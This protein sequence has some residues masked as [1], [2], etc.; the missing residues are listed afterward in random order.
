MLW[1][2]GL[3]KYQFLQNILET[4]NSAQKEA[5]THKDGPLL[6]IA[7]AG[8]GKTRVLTHRILHLIESK[9][10]SAEQIL[11]LTFTEKA[12]LEVQERLDVLLPYG[13]SELWAKTFHG[14]ADAILRE[15]GLE[16]GL[17]TAYQILSQTDLVLLL[18]KHLFE[19][20]LKYYRPLGNPLR[21][22]SA[23]GTHFGH[24]R[25]ELVTP[26]A[27][28]EY[29]E[30]MEGEEE[31]IAKTIE[32]A[33]AYKK[34]DELLL[35]KG[36]LDFATLQY[37]AV[38][39]LE[40]KPSIL[41]EYKDRFRYVLVDEYQDTN[42]AQN[43]LVELI[44]ESHK[45]LMVVGDDDQCIYKWRGASLSNILQ[46]EQNFKD[47]KKVVLTENYRSTQPVLDLS[48]AVIQNN[49]PFRLE[50]RAGIDKKLNSNLEGPAP[51][52]HS[53]H[54]S[55]YSKE[56][57]FVTQHIQ[58]Y[59]NETKGVSYRDVAILVRAT[60]H[61]LPFLE[62]LKQAGIP[63]YFSG[64]Q[65]LYLRPEVKDLLSVLR[66][67]ANPYDDVALFRF[68][69]MSIFS[70]ET[71]YLVGLVHKSKTTTTPLLK[72][73]REVEKE[74][75]LFAKTDPNKISLESFL[76]L[77]EELQTMIKDSAT[78]QI[79]GVFLKKSGYLEALEQDETPESME[80]L[81]N[82]AAFSQ[83]IRSFEETQGSPRLNE[84]LDYLLS[85]QEMGDRTSPP[86]EALDSDT[87]KILTVH[88]AKGLEFDTVLLVDLVQ[89]RFPSI[90][91][92][93]PLTVPEDLLSEQVDQEASHL[94]EERRLFYVAATRAKRHLFLTHS[95][96]YDGK[97]R[98]KPSVFLKEAHNFMDSTEDG[99]KLVDL[100]PPTK[101]VAATDSLGDQP[102]LFTYERRHQP[103]KLSFSRINTFQTCPLRYK[104]QYLYRLAEPLSHQLSFGS[105]VH[106][107]L[108]AFY[109][110]VKQ[111]ATPSLKRLNELYEKH[112]IPL[113]Y[114]SSAHHQ[115]RREEGLKIL[116]EFFETSSEN[117]WIVP[118]YLER[119]FTLKTP[120]GLSISGRID[121]IDRL[122]DG[123]YE[124]IDYKTG[125]LQ[126]QK[127]VDKDLQLSIYALACEKVL[128]LPVTK[129]SLYYLGD[130]TKISTTRSLNQL[131]DTEL[132]LETVA[133]A[134]DSSQFEAKPSPFSCQYCDYRLICNK[135][136]V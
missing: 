81:Q 24:L 61:A 130:N 42:T 90:G 91:R 48:Y 136:V 19:F 71:E 104:F 66:L 97:K 116:S 101:T 133:T 84:C 14:F 25:D 60:A 129:L 8:T 57:N 2:K 15:R 132:E 12:A 114:T 100:K 63:Y 9:A 51:K 54:F 59:L 126:D 64:S 117:G 123:S 122:P 56:V 106:N 69:S 33:R 120:S 4:L 128:K 96:Y 5:V 111:G 22:L 67:L 80:K 115:A 86:D 72:I 49:N 1:Y 44:S 74:P 27:Y 38:N 62:S 16:I 127:K 3:F 87:V 103:L 92:R 93:E 82:I 36:L 17:D 29:A 83:I 6:I 113:G 98:W 77:F 53:I 23:L 32:L 135:S 105:S 76:S 94:H 45:N 18:K 70:F 79:M 75:D 124:V 7:G 47:A 43:R 34:Y 13:Y 40:Q 102:V 11:A 68:L 26:V 28:L 52:P 41:Q 131:S 30:T 89:H 108:N 50:D 134:I 95:D 10:A 73:L 20:E 65:G 110:E 58:N 46:F 78:S 112:W 107:A 85:R 125:R 39:L 88:A 121:R 35:K 21:F 118:A 119:P 37:L 31:E 55:H 99:D 109:Q